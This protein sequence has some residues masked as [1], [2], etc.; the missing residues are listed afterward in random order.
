MENIIIQ[1]SA[2]GDIDQVREFY[3]KVDYD[4]YIN[5]ECRI[6]VARH[7]GE[8]IGVARVCMENSIRMLRGM[9]VAPEFQRQGIGSRI[10]LLINSI[11]KN[12]ECLVLPYGHL[13]YFYSQIGFKKI[14]EEDSPGFL[15]ERIAGY[16]QE[17]PDK[18]FIIMKK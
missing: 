6:V 17:M 11:L 4:S 1:E 5:P 18:T 2:P 10:L 3:K 12:Q 7:D 16:R 9:E 15:Q 14:K 13:E 8:I